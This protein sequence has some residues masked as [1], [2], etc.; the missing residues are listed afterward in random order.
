MNK[1]ET[2]TPKQD[3]VSYELTLDYD[4]VLYK[5]VFASWE[6]YVYCIPV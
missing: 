3:S 2:Y 4:S 1:K 5:K 6:E